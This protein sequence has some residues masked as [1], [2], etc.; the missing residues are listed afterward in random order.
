MLVTRDSAHRTIGLLFGKEACVV[1]VLR[2]IECLFDQVDVLV[3]HD[4]KRAVF[5]FL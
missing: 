2:E 1:F 5:K 3:F 4:P